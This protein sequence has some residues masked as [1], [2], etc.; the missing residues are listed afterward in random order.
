VVCLLPLLLYA[1]Y[2]KGL[3]FGSIYLVFAVL[4]S[5]GLLLRVGRIRSLLN[6]SAWT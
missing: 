4:M 5:A 6:R 3:Q 1:A 2:G